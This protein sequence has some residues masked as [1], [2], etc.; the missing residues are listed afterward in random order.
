MAVTT[1]LSS[2][3][4]NSPTDIFSRFDAILDRDERSHEQTAAIYRAMHR[5]RKKIAAYDDEDY[6]TAGTRWFHAACSISRR[7]AT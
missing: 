1:C 4:R 5:A 3:E 6:K 2:G 7:L